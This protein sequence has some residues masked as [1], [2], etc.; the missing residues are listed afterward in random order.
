MSTGNSAIKYLFV[1]AQL[2]ASRCTRISVKQ[3]ALAAVLFTSLT[4]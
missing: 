3:N 4:V 2:G 1:F